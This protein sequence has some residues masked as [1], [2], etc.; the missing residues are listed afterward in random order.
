MEDGFKSLLIGATLVAL[1]GMLILSATY[2]IGTDYDME[3]LDIVVGGATGI[4]EFNDSITDIETD[5]QSLK[6]RF[7]SG[8]VWSAVVG[9][10]VEGIFGIAKDM[11]S[12]I[13]LPVTFV[14]NIM[15]DRFGI[16]TY[17]TSVISGIIIFA[18][19]FGIW[20]LIKIGD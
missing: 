16:P 4:T 11:F 8:S 2:E 5:A 18:V 10:V 14:G 15:E 20:R 9:V 1:F 19:I 3:D 6:A 17:F 13:F 12:M 7:E